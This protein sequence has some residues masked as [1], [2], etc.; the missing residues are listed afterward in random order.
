MDKKVLLMILDGWGL[1]SN[2][3]GNAVKAANTPNL[4][5]LLA[6]YPNSTLIASGEDVGLPTGVMGNSEV[7]HINI[8]AGR[9]VY[10]LNTFIDKMIREGEFYDNKALNNG[11]THAAENNSNLHLFILLSDGNVHSNLN[12]LEGMLELCRRRSF[13]RVFLHAFM[14]G[15]DTLPQSGIDFMRYYLAKVEE[16]KLGKLATVSGRYYSMD[17]DN[18]WDRIQKAY[19]A[20]VNGE[21]EPITDPIEGI[22]RSYSEGLTDEFIIPKVVFENGRPVAKVKD[23]DAI[24]FLNYRADRTR[25]LTRAFISPDFNLFATK[26]LNYLKFVSMSEYDSS[27]EPYLEV[28]FRAEEQKQ[29]LG[30]VVADSGLKQ[31]RIAETEKYA[32]VTFFFNSGREEPFMKE[33]RILVPS[34]KV[35]S[36]DLQPE[37]SAVEIKENLTEAIIKGEHSLIVT[38]FAN[39]DMVGHTGVFEATVKAVE[40]VDQCIGEIYPIAKQGGYDVI[41]TADHGNAEK[42]VDEDS[43]IFTAHT[44]NPVPVI[45][46]R[47]NKVNYGVKSGKLADL[48]PTILDLLGIPIP[49]EMTGGTLL[50]EE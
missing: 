11:V 15:R 24:V 35:A 4:D 46:I 42:M 44:T 6:T 38:N 47:Q 39:C 12:H 50:N 18:R 48:A 16:Y 21:G 5:K 27:F 1:S 45:I 31:L 25:Q 43:N 28:A 22:E 30:E 37:M 7:G 2:V 10:Q 36:Y 20:I 23:N 17:R 32:H 49:S 19:E 34:P 26:P 3:T 13:D 40:T 41:I 9:V 29:I 8:G 14:D 33:E